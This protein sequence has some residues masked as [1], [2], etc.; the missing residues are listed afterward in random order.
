MELYIDDSYISKSKFVLEYNNDQTICN[1]S[2]IGATV[3]IRKILLQELSNYF[4]TILDKSNDINLYIDYNIFKYILQYIYDGKIYI[5]NNNVT[6]LFIFSCK[7]SIEFISDSCINF[8]T[9]YIDDN[10]CVKYFRLGFFHGYYKLYSL[11]IDYI[12]RRFNILEST[13][14]LLP[15]TSTELKIILKSSDVYVYS[16]DTILDFIIK[17]SKFKKNNRKRSLYLIQEILRPKFLTKDGIKKLNNWLLKMKNSQII[18]FSDGINIYPRKSYCN[19]DMPTAPSLNMI[20]FD[21][22]GINHIQDV[23]AY[24][25]I[26]KINKIVDGHFP[27]CGS[28]LLNNIVFLIGGMIDRM[29]SSNKVIGINI[30][31]SDKIEVPNLL[32]PRKCPAV[33]AF[34]NRIY[35]IGGIDEFPLKA[36]ESWSPGEKKW[37]LETDLNYPRYNSCVCVI[38]NLIYVIGGIMENDKTVEIFSPFT[39][40]WKMGTPTR[41]SHYGGCI[42]Y[43]HE[44][45]YVIGGISYI[46]NI[47]VFNIVESY[48]PVI[49]KWSIEAS[50]NRPRFNASVCEFEDSIM[51]IGGFCNKYISEIEVFS[52]DVNQWVVAGS[53]EVD[54]VLR[55]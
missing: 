33:V 32:Y 47:E 36:V 17:W 51:V 48:D 5:N 10:K 43:Y 22:H 35:V 41:Y 37:R 30:N 12:R 7:T 9:K 34:K 54:D 23:T 49:C 44:K 31:T 3:G 39:N 40:V 16:E 53:I 21:E 2:M 13:S 15:L 55:K 29:V 6:D 8:I 25:K 18:N 4:R 28:V 20:T 19:Y 27:Y 11:A 46:D 52:D 42:I 26:S 14:L 24:D 45:L 50:L 1:V 38:D